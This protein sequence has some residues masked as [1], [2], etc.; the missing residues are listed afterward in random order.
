MLVIRQQN[1]LMWSLVC[2]ICLEPK[3]SVRA[4]ENG[5]MTTLGGKKKLNH[6]WRWR[7]LKCMESFFLL[8]HTLLKVGVLKADCITTFDG[9]KKAA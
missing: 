9:R 3:L 7:I 5:G 1:R 2:V 6:E 4:S 8:R